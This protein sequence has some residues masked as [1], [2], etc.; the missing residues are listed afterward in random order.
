LRKPLV[1]D[2]HTVSSPLASVT[3]RLSFD[4]FRPLPAGQLIVNVP[5]KFSALRLAWPE[6]DQRLLDLHHAG[7]VDDLARESGAGPALR[8]AVGGHPGVAG[9]AQVNWTRA[10]GLLACRPRGLWGVAL[11]EIFRL[12]EFC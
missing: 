4:G 12:S 7:R 2:P 5:V 6:V 10:T 1:I 9:K 3:V 8:A 11:Y